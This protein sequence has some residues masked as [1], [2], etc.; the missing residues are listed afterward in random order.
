MN[1]AMRRTGVIALVLLGALIVQVTWVGF[2]EHDDY[3]ILSNT[4]T[5]IAEYEVPRGDIVAG[6]TV[7]A[8]SVETE[9]GSTYDYQRQYPAGE[10]FANLTGYKSRIYGT[11]AGGIEAVENEVLNGTSSLL[12]LDDFWASASG[13]PKPGGDVHLTIDPELQQA[14]YDA[15]A[16]TGSQGAAVVVDPQTGQVLAQVSY[17]GWDPTEVSS[18]DGVVAEEAKNALDGDEDNPALDRALRDFYPPGSTFKTIVAAAFIENGGDAESMVPA[19][20]GYT[21]PDTDHEIT[22][23]DDQCPED[24]LTLKEAFKRSC[25]TTFAQL[26]VEELDDDDIREMAEAFGFGEEYSTTAQSVASETGDLSAEAFRA[27]A[28]IGQQ[29]VRETVMQNALIAAAIANDGERMA[30]QVIAEITNSAGEPVQRGDEDSL[31]DAVS[32]S[33]AEELREIMEACL[34]GGTGS[35]A[36]IDGLT[37]GG[38]TGTAEHSTEAD[39]DEA[40]HGWFHG[41]AMGDDEDDSVAVCVFLDSYGDGGSSKAAEISG[42]LMEQALS[43]E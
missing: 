7:L 6:D 29:E 14:A 11:G 4:R 9:P 42:D 27:Q 12:F 34:D 31:G 5:T 10:A 13:E 23:A 38:K 24:E 8:T 15:I 22:N 25:N 30:P 32:S 21:A 2:F 26:C 3:D 28:C 43:G 40:N 33:T 41:W 18:N 35:G 17:P 1:P 39:G 37:V 36:E 19:G 20:N 16:E